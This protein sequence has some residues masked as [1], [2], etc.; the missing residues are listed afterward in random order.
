M[1][2]SADDTFFEETR[3]SPAITQES[4]LD[5]YHEHGIYYH[6][7][8]EI[9]NLAAALGG[10]AL[11][12]KGMAKFIS[13]ALKDPRARSIIRPFLAGRFTNIYVLGRDKGK[14]YAHTTDPDQDHRI[15]IYMWDRGTWL[16][17]S[18]KSHTQS[19]V[20][21]AGSNRLVQIPY[22]QLH[23]SNEFRINL[24]TGGM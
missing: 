20:G 10:E 5:F 8:A 6:E 9:G 23:G 12:Q 17:F 2:T 22:V 21:I 4:A 1:A 14:F 7:D 15:V 16:E 13:L 3:I 24:N 11:S 19:F 18:H